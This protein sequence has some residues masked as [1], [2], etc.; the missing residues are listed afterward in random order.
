MTEQ[1]GSY[2]ETKNLTTKT[3]AQK[4]QFDAL[5]PKNQ[6]FDKIKF[7]KAWNSWKRLPFVVSKGAQG[8]FAEFNDWL[9][10]QEEDWEA[11]LEK[12]L[13]Y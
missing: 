4:K 6:T 5:R 13:L 3:L 9:S 8:N 10:C 11:F 12:Q 1:R 7:A 2:N